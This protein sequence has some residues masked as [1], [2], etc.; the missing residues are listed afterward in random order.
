[1]SFLFKNKYLPFVFL[2]IYFLIGSYLS[3]SNGITSDEYHE[4]LNWD[5][6]FK[7]ILSFFKTGKYDELINYGDRYH[8]IAFHYISQ[9]FQLVFH[10]VIANLNNLTDF[11]GYLISKHFV[12]FLLFFISG[13]FFYLLSKKITNNLNF[14]LLSTILYLLY[15]YLFGHA[16]F[17]PKDIPFLSFWLINTYISLKIIE[18]LFN[19]KK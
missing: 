7:G 5:V 11:G 3:I 19:E 13:I 9:P 6:N 4:Q 17:N 16:H 18:D 8:G 15:P 10:K 1:M 14:S 12:I 2:T